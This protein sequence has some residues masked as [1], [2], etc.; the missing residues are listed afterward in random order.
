MTM[1]EDWKE[2]MAYAPLI[3][4]EVDTDYQKIEDFTER[5]RKT[6]EKERTLVYGIEDYFGGNEVSEE[7]VL[8]EDDEEDDE[9]EVEIGGNNENNRII[10]TYDKFRNVFTLCRSKNLSVQIC[11]CRYWRFA[12]HIAEPFNFFFTYDEYNQHLK[13]SKFR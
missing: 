11:F 3:V 7:L 2:N 12:K 10:F 8:L 4:A 9:I 1:N 6:A 13:P 5:D